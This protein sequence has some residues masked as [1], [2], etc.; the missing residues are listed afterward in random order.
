MNSVVYN[1]RPWS[2]SPWASS[3]H[4]HDRTRLSIFRILVIALVLASAFFLIKDGLLAP[5][6]ATK[7][8]SHPPNRVILSIG[9]VGGR[10]DFLAD[11]LPSLFNQTWKV[12]M[13]VITVTKADVETFLA[14]LAPWG[15]FKPDDDQ[16]RIPPNASADLK[17]AVAGRKIMRGSQGLVV[18]F[19]PKDWGE[20]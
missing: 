7:R 13:V 11:S 5:P 16:W 2:A 19:L 3:N 8:F 20:T 6:S 14:A 18:Q 1:R 4:A 9:T 15:P 10:S 17:H 12:D